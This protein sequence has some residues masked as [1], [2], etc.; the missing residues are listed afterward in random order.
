MMKKTTK[1]I[2]TNEKRLKFT[3]NRLTRNPIV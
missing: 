1:K 3:E 2:T